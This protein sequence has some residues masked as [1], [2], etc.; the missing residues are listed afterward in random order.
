MEA[1]NP[2]ADSALRAG[3]TGISAEEPGTVKATEE[4]PPVSMV[5]VKVGGA[6]PKGGLGFGSVEGGNPF[7]LRLL[8]AF[9]DFSL[10]V[11]FGS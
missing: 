1:C 7:P 6:A 8:G 11:F 3:S 10:D 4:D 9:F 2:G 5:G